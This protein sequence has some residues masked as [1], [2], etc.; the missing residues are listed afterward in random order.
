MLHGQRVNGEQRDGVGK[1]A[2]H[3]EVL[4]CCVPVG[5][6]WKPMFSDGA[7]YLASTLSCWCMLLVTE[8]MPHATAL[9]LP[10]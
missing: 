6:G 1:R 5:L 9:L 10:C 4:L 7:G 2:D 8:Y 3:C